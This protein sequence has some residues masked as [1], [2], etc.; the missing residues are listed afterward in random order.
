MNIFLKLC[1]ISLPLLISGIMLY[2]GN[3]TLYKELNDIDT[4]YDMFLIF[5][6][7]LMLLSII[8]NFILWVI[9]L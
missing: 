9:Y 1:L 4:K 6:N 8:A 5:F 7:I 2:N 3:R